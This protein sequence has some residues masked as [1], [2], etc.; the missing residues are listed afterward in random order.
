MAGNFNPWIWVS[1]RGIWTITKAFVRVRWSDGGSELC[2]RLCEWMNLR[3]LYDVRILNGNFSIMNFMSAL[4]EPISII[5]I[6][7]RTDV[8]FSAMMR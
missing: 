8:N 7:Q 5:A 3:N 2:V 6:K 1:G 4:L